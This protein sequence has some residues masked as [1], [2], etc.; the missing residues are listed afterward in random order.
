MRAIGEVVKAA[1]EAV[2]PLFESKHLY[3]RAELPP[4]LPPIYGDRTRIR[5]VILN[6]L[7]NAGRFTEHGGGLYKRMAG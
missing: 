3:L 6:L 4:D 7:S 2:R 1:V 5:E